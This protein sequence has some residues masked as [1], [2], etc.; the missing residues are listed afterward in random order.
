MQATVI[1][2]LRYANRLKDAGVDGVQAEAMAFAINDELVSGLAT[3]GDI[4]RAADGFKADL[5][6]AVGAL[7]GELERAVGDLR[8]DMDNAIGGL[9]TDMDNAIGGLRTDM[10]HAIGDLR[11]DMAA[12][13]GKFETQGRYVFLVLALIAALGLFNAVAPHVGR[14]NPAASPPVE[15]SA[16]PSASASQTPSVGNPDAG[17]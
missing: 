16:P 13:N 7:R 15:V 3:K 6:Q 11:T 14:T 5:D 17:S 10:D 8:T 12:L 4:D 9:R 1:D 2:T